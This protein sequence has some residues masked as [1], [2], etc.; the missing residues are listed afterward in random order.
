MA[1]LGKRWRL[2]T[3][4]EELQQELSAEFKISPVTAQVLINRGLTDKEAVR[5]F[6]YG[7]EIYNPY[8]LKDMDR[9][10]ERIHLALSRQEKI[11]IFGDYDVDGITAS[12]LVYKFLSRL[13]GRVAYYIPQRLSEGYGLNCA[14]LDYLQENGT[15]LIITVDCGISAETEVGYINKKIDVIITDHHQ[16]PE[17]LPAA[18]AIVNPKQPGCSYPDKNLAG[19]GVAYKLCQALCRHVCFDEKELDGLDLVALGTIADIVPLLNENRVLVKQG[20]NVLVDRNNIG[21]RVLMQEC[22]LPVGP[23]DSDKIAFIVAPRL[24]AAG[25]VGRADVAVELLITTDEVR[26]RELAGFLENENQSRKNIEK[27]ILAEAEKFVQSCSDPVLVLSGNWHPGVIGIVA[28]RLVDTYYCPVV[29]ISVQNG[30]GKASCRSIAAFDMYQ[31]LQKCSDLLT[32]FGGHAQAAGFG[33]D[34]S[35]IEKFRQR[36]NDIARQALSEEDYQKELAI[37]AWTT[38]KEVDFALLE[39]LKCL[40]PYGAGNPVPLLA[41]RDVKVADVRTV[42][43]KGEHLKMQVRESAFFGDVI[44]WQMGDLALRFVPGNRVDIVFSPEINEWNGHRKIQ[45]RALDIRIAVKLGGNRGIIE[46][47][48]VLRETIPDRTVTGYIY[49]VLKQLM[50]RE[51]QL[52][53]DQAKIADI[54]RRKYKV[55]VNEQGINTAMQILSE[56]KLLHLKEAGFQQFAVLAKPPEHKLD[57]EQSETF[58]AGMKRLNEFSADRQSIS[59]GETF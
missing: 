1:K 23:I 6:L 49:L 45:L 17:K 11:T 18:Y 25:R 27:D 28:S 57:I 14:A 40:A 8:L 52:L 10:V 44:A 35:N 54:I 3:V 59:N 9:A 7:E 13:G 51:R 39:E 58:R 43:Q 5:R 2:A 4:P 42:G 48:C 32:H 55:T 21:L 50:G 19:V 38:V 47:L 24:N 26:A 16:P 37:D 53:I 41:C 36:L 46:T 15:G 30:T 29:M 22:G 12:A 31:A 20:L 56:L 33:I 34:P